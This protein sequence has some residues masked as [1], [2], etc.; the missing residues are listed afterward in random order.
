MTTTAAVSTIAIRA[1]RGYPQPRER[2][3]GGAAIIETIRFYHEYDANGYLSNFYA[4]RIAVEG[5][6]WPTAEHYYQACKT[7]DAAYAARIRSAATPDEAKRLGNDAACPLRADWSEHRVRAMRAALFAKFS[8]HP[9][10]RAALLAT[11]DAVL[12]ED[13][14][15]DAYWGAGA[16][17]NGLSMLGKLLMEL[18]DC[19]RNRGVEGCD[20]RG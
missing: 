2:P 9:D 16:D 3:G 15:R 11:G 4:S 5:A 1:P 8:Q 19:L 17:G 20:P 12:V 18:R 6:E 13:S 10:L 14:K 7:Q